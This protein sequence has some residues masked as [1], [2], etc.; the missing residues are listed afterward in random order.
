MRRVCAKKLA[1]ILWLICVLLGF[2]PAAV[3]LFA[4]HVYEKN[5]DNVHS[6]MPQRGRERERERERKGER[7][8]G[9]N[10]ER[11]SKRERAKE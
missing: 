8:R 6:V 10:S 4:F 5:S 11:K 1:G 3:S 2:R 7:Y 9:S